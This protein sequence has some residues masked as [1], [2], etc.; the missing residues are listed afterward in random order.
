MLDSM[1]LLGCITKLS[2]NCPINGNVSVSLVIH[3]ERVVTSSVSKT[4]EIISDGKFSN[5]TKETYLKPVFARRITDDIQNLRMK[6]GTIKIS[7]DIQNGEVKKYSLIP[8]YTL[9]ANLLNAELKSHEKRLR[10]K[11]MNQSA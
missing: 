4:T 5:E 1:L 2:F 11:K 3:N 6:Y 8:E 7:V 10:A 9:N